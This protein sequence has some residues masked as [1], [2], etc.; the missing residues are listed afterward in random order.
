MTHATGISRTNLF[1]FPALS[2]KRRSG[3]PAKCYG[4]NCEPRTRRR[5]A[6]K[7]IESSQIYCRSII[8]IVKM[9]EKNNQN[10]VSIARRGGRISMDNGTANWRESEGKKVLPISLYHI[11]R[12][13]METRR[14]A[15]ETGRRM[16]V[17]RR[18]IYNQRRASAT[19]ARRQQC[20]QPRRAPPPAP[21]L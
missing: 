19:P 12:L 2:R 14:L 16:G 13:R 5:T 15:T 11:W 9:R 6:K 10:V 1:F 4:V 8:S 18:F 3:G 17:V 7:K 21:L 20:S